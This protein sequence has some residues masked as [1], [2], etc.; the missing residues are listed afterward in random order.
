MLNSS[1]LSIKVQVLL[2]FSPTHNYAPLVTIKY[3]VVLM[4]FVEKNKQQLFELFLVDIVRGA[5][6]PVLRVQI[7]G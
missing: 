4:D 1:Y 2:D 5:M 3:M 7:I 6:V